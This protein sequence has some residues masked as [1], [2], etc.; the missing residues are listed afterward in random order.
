MDK[1]FCEDPVF[2]LMTFNHSWEKTESI[3]WWGGAERSV[4][5]VAFAYTGD[6]ISSIQR[7]A[8][9]DYRLN[10]VS[11]I[12]NNLS[13][14]LQYLSENFDSK[15]SSKGIFEK[16]TP[17]SVVFQKDGTWGI[18]FDCIFD[19]EN[20]ISLYKNT[21]NKWSVGLQDDFL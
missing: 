16:I 13:L 6:Q 9:E 5:I 20:G 17:R 10:V 18:L 1:K 8:Y 12:D 2:G 11:V 19:A 14:L 4:N 3:Y 15:I 21:N 7:D